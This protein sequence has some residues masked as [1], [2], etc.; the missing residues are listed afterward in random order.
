ME[1]MRQRTEMLGR[2]SPLFL[3]KT[4][5]ETTFVEGTF[6]ERTFVEKRE[7]ENRNVW[8]NCF[9]NFDFEEGCFWFDS[10]GNG[11]RRF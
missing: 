3:R 10:F 8:L 11:D 5:I 6:V 2:N 7:R 9:D 1:T 4:F